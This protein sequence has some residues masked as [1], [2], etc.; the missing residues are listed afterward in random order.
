MR[1]RRMLDIPSFA[2]AS[3]FHF[4]YDKL[5]CSPDHTVQR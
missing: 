5:C 3:V 2:C 1:K 4:R